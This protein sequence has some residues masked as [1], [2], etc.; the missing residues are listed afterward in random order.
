MKPRT[1]LPFDLRGVAIIPD[2]DNYFVRSYDCAAD[3]SFL[4]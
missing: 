2:T 4:N 1:R 3:Y